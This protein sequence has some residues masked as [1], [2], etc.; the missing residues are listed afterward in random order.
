VKKVLIIGGGLAGLITGIR[1]ARAGVLV[2]L[3]EKRGYP[4]HRVCGEYISNEAVPFLKSMGLYPQDIALPQL[5]RFQLSSTTGRS[6]ILP[7]DM[8]GFGISRYTFDQLLSQAAVQAGV[9]VRQQTEVTKVVYSQDKFVVHAQAGVFEADV[10]VGCHGKRSRLDMALDRGF[11]KRR[12]PYV[13]VKYHLRI[14]H[15]ADL[16][17]LH[18]F[19]GGYCGISNIEDGKTNLCYLVHR[20]VL[21]KH[22][23]VEAMERA[24]LQKNPLLGSIFGRAEFLFDRPEV[25]NEISFETK[26]VVE[27]HILMAGDAAGMIT[28]LCG[29]G[30]AMAIHSAKLLSDEVLAFC[31]GELSRNEMEGQ[32]TARWK[33][34]FARRL[35]AGRQV[36]RLFGNIYTSAM[37]IGLA[38]YV[39]PVA[40]GIIKNTHGEVF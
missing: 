12:S 39:K 26:T 11:I 34:H 17:A 27:D 23:N 3:V 19:E 2:T 9:D 35:W 13:G 8:G 40:R 36:Q 20:D 7:L 38:L 18:N 25:I 14:D 24:V 4:F 30:M 6:S 28:P 29:N 33:E 22:G 5:R 1:L 15:P 21:K 16:I 32:Y 10:V 31:R 37:A